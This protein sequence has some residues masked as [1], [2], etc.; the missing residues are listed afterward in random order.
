MLLTFFTFQ[1]CD[2][3]GLLSR[4]GPRKCAPLRRCIE[5]KGHKHGGSYEHKFAKD[6]ETSS[7][8]Q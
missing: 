3:P 8:T 1:K 2:D 6:N 7:S 4:P 5:K